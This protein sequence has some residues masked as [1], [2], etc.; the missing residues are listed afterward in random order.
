MRP[1][2]PLARLQPQPPYLRNG[3]ELLLLHELIKALDVWA[4]LWPV[5][6]TL[7]LAQVWTRGGQ[8]LCQALGTQRQDPRYP[9]TSHKYKAWTEWLKEF[10]CTA[11]GKHL[12]MVCHGGRRTSR[13]GFLQAAAFDLGLCRVWA[14]EVSSGTWGWSRPNAGAHLEGRLCA[15]TGD[16]AGGPRMGKDQ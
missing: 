1:W 15:A 12:V 9:Q 3:V 16:C 6:T 13:K 4:T 5:R 7:S 14:G 2:L 10:A 11:P 8:L